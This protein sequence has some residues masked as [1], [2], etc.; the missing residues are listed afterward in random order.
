MWHV[1]LRAPRINGDSFS[2]SEFGRWF[3]EVLFMRSKIA[4]PL[5][6]YSCSMH[7]IRALAEIP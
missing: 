4:H 3:V 1:A 5:E 6:D 7:D 2:S